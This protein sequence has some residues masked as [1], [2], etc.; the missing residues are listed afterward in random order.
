MS[1]VI[2]IVTANSFSD[3][4]MSCIANQDFFPQ[5]HAAAFIHVS[6]SKRD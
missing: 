2:L 4:T 6:G 5:H 1:N 3:V